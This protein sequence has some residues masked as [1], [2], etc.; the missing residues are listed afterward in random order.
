MYKSTIIAVVVIYCLTELV[1]RAMDLATTLIISM[2]VPTIE[3]AA[4]RND[5]EFPL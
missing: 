1:G 3:D 2:P 4:C 5:M